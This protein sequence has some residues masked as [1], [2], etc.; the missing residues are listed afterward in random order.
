[1]NHE[2]KVTHG[3]MNRPFKSPHFAKNRNTH[4]GARNLFLRPYSK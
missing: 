4:E 1:M 2:I 3:V